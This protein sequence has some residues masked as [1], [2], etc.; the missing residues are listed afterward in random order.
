[1][2]EPAQRSLCRS[3]QWPVSAL[4]LEGAAVGSAAASQDGCIRTSRTLT[5][6]SRC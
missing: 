4:P 1:M 2:I 5:L 3:N 6:G